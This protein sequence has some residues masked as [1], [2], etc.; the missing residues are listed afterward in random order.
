ML[1]ALGPFFAMTQQDG[2]SD[3]WISLLGAT[4][5]GFGGWNALK[6]GWK[7]RKEAHNERT[8]MV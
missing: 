3:Y 6:A 1:A 7:M 2:T 4:A 8:P 5:L